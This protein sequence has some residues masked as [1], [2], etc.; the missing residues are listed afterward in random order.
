MTNMIPAIADSC[1]EMQSNDNAMRD[2]VHL[3]ECD[4]W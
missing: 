4:N 1:R 3:A 2:Y